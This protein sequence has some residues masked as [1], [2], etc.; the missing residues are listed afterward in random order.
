M[1]VGRKPRHILSCHWR[2]KELE[3]LTVASIRI[4]ERGNEKCGHEEV[5]INN[6]IGLVKAR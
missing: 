4:L 6:R 2:K 5:W 1:S 3:I